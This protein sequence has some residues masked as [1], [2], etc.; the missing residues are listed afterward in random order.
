MFA[1]GKDILISVL[2]SLGK[3]K[4]VGVRESQN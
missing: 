3:E 1:D 4:V 2:S